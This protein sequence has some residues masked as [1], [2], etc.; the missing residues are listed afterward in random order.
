MDEQKKT[1]KGM[2][3]NIQY[4]LNEKVKKGLRECAKGVMCSSTE[5]PYKDDTEACFGNDQLLKDALKAIEALEAVLISLNEL[6]VDEEASK[7]VTMLRLKDGN[8]EMAGNLPKVILL[9]SM[10]ALALNDQ[11]EMP[12]PDEVKMYHLAIV[13]EARKAIKEKEAEGANDD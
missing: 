7:G 3:S 11:Y 8:I 9:T 1:I 12:M 10:A 6:K 2:V 5:C 4:E 13:K